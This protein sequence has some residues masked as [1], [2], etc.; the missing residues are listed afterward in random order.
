MRRAS[1]RFRNYIATIT[2]V[3]MAFLVAAAGFA[4]GATSVGPAAPFGRS[5]DGIPKTYI[6][7][8][9]LFGPESVFESEAKQ[10]AQILGTRL[11]SDGHVLVRYNDKRGGTATLA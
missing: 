1:R 5:R 10:A 3:A 9:G 6:V 4:Q 11:H 8:F 7:S 2:A